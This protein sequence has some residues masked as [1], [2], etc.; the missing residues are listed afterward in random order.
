[1]GG[2]A[3]KELGTIP[4][5]ATSLRGN[6]DGARLS[7]PRL[8]E[9]YDLLRQTGLLDYITELQGQIREYEAL[10]DELVEI[11]QQRTLQGLVDA[12]TG[13]LLNRIVPARLVFVV[14]EDSEFPLIRTYCFENMRPVEPFVKVT[15]LEPFRELF[16]GEGGNGVAPISFPDISDVRITRVLEPAQPELIFPLAGFAGIHGFVAV[17]RKVIDEP[18]SERERRHIS[19]LIELASISLEN[20]LHHKRAITDQK[21][22]LYNYSFF[23]RQAERELDRIKRHGG[24]AALLVVDIDH[25]KRFNDSHGHLAGDAALRELADSLQRAIRSEDLAARFGGEEFV[26]L[27][28]ECYTDSVWG[29]C[30]RIRRSVE[31]MPIVH[32]G[33]ELRITVSVGGALISREQ[34]RP[35]DQVIQQADTALYRAKMEGRNR[36]VL[37]KASLSFVGSVY[38]EAL[39]GI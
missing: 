21:T 7:D 22:Q 6:D 33:R 25:F 36:T 14:D 37:Y 32:E 18:F 20:N 4:C 12:V 3:V 13:K 19:R 34:M 17:S 30:E 9:H 11:S 39:C 29:A 31:R 23:R 28:A 2:V 38:R 1:V 26:V 16:G 8:I 5:G 24:S 35:L 10:L 15:S 27:L